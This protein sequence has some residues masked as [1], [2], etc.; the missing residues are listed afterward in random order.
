MKPNSELE[1]NI[2]QH[3]SIYT[4]SPKRGA[5][6]RRPANSH[7][8]IRGHRRTADNKNKANALLDQLAHEHINRARGEL[9]TLFAIEQ[10]LQEHG[11]R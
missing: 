2:A 8:E 4:H 3:E 1:L 9:E 5:R 10:R 11:W 6:G 7:K